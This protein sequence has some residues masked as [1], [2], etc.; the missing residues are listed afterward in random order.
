MPAWGVTSV[1]TSSKELEQIT[2]FEV[3]GTGSN[4]SRLAISVPTVGKVKS[5]CRA[6]GFSPANK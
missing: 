4:S 5:A 1:K 6:V 2:C 3:D